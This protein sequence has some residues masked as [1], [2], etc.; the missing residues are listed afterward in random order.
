M[1]KTQMNKR[2]LKGDKKIQNI[3]AYFKEIKTKSY[4][5]F[6]LNKK[7]S[8]RKNSDNES[9]ENTSCKKIIKV[10]QKMKFFIR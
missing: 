10:S 7:F 8:K 9:T 3:V 1:C 6:G 4:N 2:D 5:M